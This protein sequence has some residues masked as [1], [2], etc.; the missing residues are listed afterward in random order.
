MPLT[1]RI[2]RETVLSLLYAHYFNSENFLDF[3]KKELDQFDEQ[4]KNYGNKLLNKTLLHAKEYDELINKKLEKWEIDRV[5]IID[6][7]ILRMGLCEFMHFDEIP[8]KVTINEMI[9]LAKEY[10]N[11]KSSKFVNG[12]LDSVLSDLQSENKLKKS[13]RG[14]IEQSYEK[15][16]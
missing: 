15:N 7:L 1:R 11:S 16:S 3:A 10:S 8:P 2:I 9:E 4:Y 5:P 6:R 12:I 13:G 14:L